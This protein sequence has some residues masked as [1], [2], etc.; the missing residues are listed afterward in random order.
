MSHVLLK[1]LKAVS[2]RDEEHINNKEVEIMEKRGKGRLE[3]GR[4]D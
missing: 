4:D 2:T 1:L 3:T